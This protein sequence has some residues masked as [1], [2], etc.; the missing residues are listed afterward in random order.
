[1]KRVLLILLC[2]LMLLGM[3]ACN[4][5]EPAPSTETTTTEQNEIIAY[6]AHDPVIDRF[7]VDFIKKHTSY[8]NP[9]TI[10]RGADTSEYKAVIDQCNVVL[11]NVSTEVSVGPTTMPMY[12]LR[13]SI[14][15]GSTEES[16]ERML[17]VFAMIAR[18][19]DS[20]CTKETTD[21]AVAHLSAQKSTVADYSV[22]SNVKVECYVP[23]V[24]QH[25]VPCR[26]ELL[27]H[28]YA[29]LEK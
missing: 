2:L 13:I 1:M 15:G 19:T 6:Y 24:K 28:N 12:L 23:I 10:L 20:T 8:L 21:A 11:R 16:R 27:I 14:E 26:I 9:T 18:L 25:G 7:F 17:G 29:P 22:S 3:T 4:Q 5:P